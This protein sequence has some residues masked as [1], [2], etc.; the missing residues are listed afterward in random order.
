V[1]FKRTSIKRMYEYTVMN[2]REVGGWVVQTDNPTSTV[3]AKSVKNGS[4]L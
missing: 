2:N 3:D 1:Y 4:I